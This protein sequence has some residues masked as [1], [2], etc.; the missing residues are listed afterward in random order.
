MSS[1]TPHDLRY[2]IE[3]SYPLL[4][5]Y[6]RQRAMRELRQLQF[7]SDEVE[8]VIGHVIEQLLKVGLLGGE[9]KTPKTALDGLSPPQFYKFLNQ[10]VKHKAIDRLRKRRLLVSTVADLSVT[11]GEEENDVLNNVIESIWGMTP[12]ST[13]EEITLALASNEETRKMLKDCIERLKAAPHQYRAVIQELKEIDALE[14]LAG[15][16]EDEQKP[17]DVEVRPEHLS[18]HKDHAHKKLRHCV[19]KKSANLMVQLALRLSEYGQRTATSD[20]FVDIEAL[21]RNEEGKLDLS[22]DEVKKGLKQLVVGGLLH[23]SGEDVVHLTSSEAKRLGR[24]Y[25]GE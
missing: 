14:L 6:L 13:P 17:A 23:W 18:Q 25:E 20:K 5:T 22:K 9:D 8:T 15:L 11:G 4:E 19:Q 16:R 3:K 12:F 24:Y 7:D 10:S 1:F 2:N 21:T